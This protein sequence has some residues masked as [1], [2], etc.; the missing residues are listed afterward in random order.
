MESVNSLYLIIFVICLGLSAFFSSA[1]TAFV[2]LPKLR[3]KHLVSIQTRG[4]ERL[5]RMVAQPS[6]FLAAILL[7]N[8]LVN[9]AAAAVGTMM[10]VAAVGPAW[11]ALVATIGVTTLVLIFG[12]VIP[13][14]FAAHHAE[15]MALTYTR[16]I[17]LI[18]WILY[19]FVVVLN[20]IGLGFTKMVAETEEGKKLVSEEEIRTA[21]TVGEAEGVW[22]ETEAEMLHKAFEFADRP[23]SEAM[24]P[25]TEVTWLEQGTKLA[26][27]LE[28]Y[29]QSPYSRFPVYKENTD[30]VIGVLS[31]K[32]V[33]MAQANSSFDIESP[34]D[35][36]VR[37][38]YFVP[39]TKHLGELLTDMRDNN[40]R[41][42]V[43]IDEFGGVAG[44]ATLEQL[45]AEIVGSIGDELA[46]GERDF[47]TIDANTFEVDGGLRVEEANEELGLGLPLGEY[48]TMAGFVLSHLGRIPRQGE[49]LKY[50]DLKLAILEMRGMKIERI[51]VT[52]EGDAAPAP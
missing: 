42:A 33:L 17:E 40:Y 10:A 29:R 34:I 26:D 4:A 11:G 49:Q 13:K 43:V 9:V 44:I 31:I 38:A 18:I 36:L 47:I 41:M 28:S 25:R 8:N 35:E 23:V 2:S 3:A 37:P 45:I 21:I 6:R 48:E 46:S 7:G 14:T 16:P 1:E 20:R 51:L 30:N 15:R 52:K 5:E 19:P 12:E 39:E 50:K 22:E 24:T 32:D 27:F